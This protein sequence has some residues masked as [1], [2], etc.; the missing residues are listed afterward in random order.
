MFEFELSWGSTSY[1]HNS[2]HMIMKLTKMYLLWYLLVS[3]TVANGYA[4]KID[5]IR[6]YFAAL[7]FCNQNKISIIL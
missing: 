3:Q 7:K 6:Y 1:F 4:V 5:I 2:T